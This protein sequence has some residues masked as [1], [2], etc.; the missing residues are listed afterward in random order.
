MS[1]FGEVRRWKEG[2]ILW[3]ENDIIRMCY[4]VAENDSMVGHEGWHGPQQIWVEYISPDMAKAWE[5]CSEQLGTGEKNE[6]R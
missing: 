1:I 5:G 6:S 2:D 4:V 3:A